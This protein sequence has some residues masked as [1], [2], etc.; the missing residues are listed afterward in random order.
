MN[1]RIRRLFHTYHDPKY[2]APNRTIWEAV[3]ATSA[4]LTFFKRILID[5]EPYVD[6][7]MGCNSPIQQVLQEAQLVVPDR[8]VACIISIGAGQPRRKMHTNK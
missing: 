6:S 2:L 7:G 3:R 8:H 4:A 1:A 5:G